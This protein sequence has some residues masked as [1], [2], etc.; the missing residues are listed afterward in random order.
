M[1]DSKPS[2]GYY[3][4]NLKDVKVI[5]KDNVNILTG[6]YLK[7]DIKISL[8]FTLQD[9]KTIKLNGVHLDESGVAEILKFM[10][11]KVVQILQI[12]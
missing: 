2:F 8:S 7:D 1:D 6:Y 3:S 4:N 12:L 9:E 11:K 5:T 10:N